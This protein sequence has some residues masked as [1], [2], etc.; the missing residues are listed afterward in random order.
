[1]GQ[2]FDKNNA[3]KVDHVH[4]GD[5]HTGRQKAECDDDG[6]RPGMATAWRRFMS[7]PTEPN[8]K[9]AMPKRTSQTSWG[10]SNK[11]SE[12]L[13]PMVSGDLHA[14]VI[15]SNVQLDRTARCLICRN[16]SQKRQA[17]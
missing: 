1:M 11:K 12:F 16:K 14:S 10:S 4:S 8:A 6:A 9:L 5:A 7:K 3:D 13:E 17:V 15:I 2:G